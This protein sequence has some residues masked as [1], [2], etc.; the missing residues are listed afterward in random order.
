LTA[1]RDPSFYLITKGY[2]TP[3]NFVESAPLVLAALRGA[4][5][6]DLALVQIREKA[7]TGR[8]L[9]ELVSQ[10]AQITKGTGTKLIV[11]DRVDIALAAGADGVQLTE[12]SLRPNVVRS[13]AG[14]E[15]VIGSSVH[16]LENAQKARDD[17]ADLVVFGPVF[18]T[19]GKSQ[20][21]GVKMLRAVC[22][23]INAFPV[24]AIGGIDERNHLRV[25]DAGASGVAAIRWLND[26]VR[27]NESRTPS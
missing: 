21:Q 10:A 27:D 13:I 19:P 6:R 25:L 17:G 15:F 22:E 8:L 26:V 14:Q 23:A 9:F 1:P 18:A 16:S 12:N 11:N 3:R 24:F 20:G 2:C 5:A 7:L 4:V